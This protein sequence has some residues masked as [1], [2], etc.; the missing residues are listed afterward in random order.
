[1]RKKAPVGYLITAGVLF[2][3]LACSAIQIAT[4][5]PQRQTTQALGDY[6]DAP[7]GDLGMDTGYYGFAGGPFV[8]TLQSLG[9]QAS[10]PTVGSDP[11]PGPFTLD[12]DDFFIGPLFGDYNVADV[13]SLEDDVLDPNDPDGL[14]NLLGVPDT[15]DCDKENARHNPGATG[16]RNVPPYS[17]PENARLVI[18]FGAPPLG[19]FITTVHVSPDT[20]L[21]GPAYWNLLIDLNQDGR[22]GSGEWIAQDVPVSLNPGSNVLL[23]SPAIRWPTSGNPW[24]R[25]IFPFWARS[26]V[27]L[28]SVKA[29]MGSSTWDGRGI[30][31]GF[32][33]GEVEDYFLE[34]R[35]IGQRFPPPEPTPTP[36]MEPLYQCAPE[37]MTGVYC[38]QPLTAGQT[39]SCEISGPAWDALHVLCVPETGGASFGEG[40]LEPGDSSMTVCQSDDSELRFDVTPYGIDITPVRWMEGN[41]FVFYME[42]RSEGW[43][44]GDPLVMLSTG[45]WGIFGN[46]PEPTQ[47]EIFGAWLF[48]SVIARDPADHGPHVK[49]PKSF[50]VQIEKGSISFTGDPPWVD[51]QG[52]LNEDGTFFAEGRGTVAGFTDIA[53][54]F[55]GTIS[56]TE[57]SGEYAMGVEGGLPGGQSIVYDITGTHMREG[58]EE[59]GAE[60]GP[61]DAAMAGIREA[62]NAFIGVFN[63]AFR[64]GDVGTLLG[65]LHTAVIDRYGQ[66]AC[67]IYL[68]EVAENPISLKLLDVRRIGSWD[69]ET[70]GLST[71]IGSIYTVTA[72]RTALGSTEEVEVHLAVPGD[73]SVRWLTDCGEPLP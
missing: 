7:D 55:E 38:P 58:T 1:M 56:P 46:P 29:A 23:V 30:Q 2:L 66:D 12:V 51:V 67:R 25:L 15:A 8:Y 70:D 50:N 17:I 10:F 61:A 28:E 11:V 24:G 63:D 37:D 32:A 27:T 36:G 35:P 57:L 18:V 59:G 6:G 44:V 45:L 71:T 13:P 26:M 53:V 16:C 73:D 43:C 20:T 31:N 9:V 69:W 40:V 62:I 3:T 68:E 48:Q 21:A 65:L 41:V 72:N 19:V 64:N 52:T 5:T 14:S 33:Y 39:T 54:T 60:P 42:Q 47:L 22:W 34:W 4:P 49:L